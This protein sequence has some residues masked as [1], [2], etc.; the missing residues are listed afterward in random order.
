MKIIKYWKKYEC[1]ASREVQLVKLLATAASHMECKF[2]SQLLYFLA[3]FLLMHLG[4]QPG[5]PRCLGPCTP[6]GDPIGV[7]APKFP[8]A[9]TAFW[10]S[11]SVDRISPL[12]L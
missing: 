9:I 12:S 5:W 10:Y 6:V 11:E 2:N 3:T 4:K 7:Q 8:L 1:E